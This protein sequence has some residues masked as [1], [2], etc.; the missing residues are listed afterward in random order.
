[1][2]ARPCQPEDTAALNA[3]SQAVGTQPGRFKQDAEKEGLQNRVLKGPIQQ[4]RR[5]LS[6]TLRKK[7]LGHL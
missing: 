4:E 2:E 7:G 3:G 5:G 1:M 6:K